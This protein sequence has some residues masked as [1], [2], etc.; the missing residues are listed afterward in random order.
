M[1]ELTFDSALASHKSP[2][3]AYAMSLTRDEDRANDLM[4]ETYFRALSNRDKFAAGTNL[5]A[6]LLTIMRNI[7]INDYR[8]NSRR[9]TVFDNS[10]SGVLLELSGESAS[11]AAEGDFVMSDLKAA[12]RHLDPEYRVPFIRHHEGYK[13]HEIAEDL[14][15]PIGTVKSRIFFARKRMK[16]YLKS[17]GFER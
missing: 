1:K 15:L 2:L 13:Y 12:L 10:E 17:I 8:R 6:W 9:K 7:F 3:T 11:N 5:K 4:Q 14:N 16:E